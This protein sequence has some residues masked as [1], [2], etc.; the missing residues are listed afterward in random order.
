[1]AI[2]TAVFA[3]VA[4]TAQQDFFEITSP[5][6]AV[7]I[8]HAVKL[9]NLTEIGDVAEEMLSILHKRGATT[10]GTG[11][12]QAITP[13]PVETGSSAYGGVVDTNN[14]TKASG[15]T[16]VTL[17]ADGWNIRSPYLWLPTPELRP[18]LGPSVRFTVE[19]A[20]TPVDSI[21]INGCCY[22][23]ELGG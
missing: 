20:T 3:G 1:L 7:T 13:Q 14:T 19:L 17:D 4:V 10:T 21:T 9:A 22:F 5:A 2:Y 8:I 11:G 23:E 12:S 18:I 6:D 15:G 16:I